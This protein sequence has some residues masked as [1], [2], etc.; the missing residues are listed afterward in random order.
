MSMD[1]GGETSSADHTAGADK[2]DDHHPVPTPGLRPDP[3]PFFLP[4]LPGYSHC[5]FLHLGVQ[6]AVAAAEHCRAGVP[7]DREIETCA[8]VRDPEVYGYEVK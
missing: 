3:L 8:E 1:T 4:H 2:G 7:T 6:E 5:C